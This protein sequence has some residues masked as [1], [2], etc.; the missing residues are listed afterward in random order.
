MA[1]TNTDTPDTQSRLV[2]TI[3]AILGAVLALV[4]WWRFANF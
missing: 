4:G 2:W 3:L 1:N